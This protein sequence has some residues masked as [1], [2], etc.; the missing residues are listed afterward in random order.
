MNLI[1]HRIVGL[2]ENDHLQPLKDSIADF[3]R[4]DAAVVFSSGF[5]ALKS[6]IPIIP[7][8]YGDDEKAFLLTRICQNRNIVVLPVVSSTVPI[9]LARFC[10]NV[11]AA[12][13]KED[14][15]MV[16][17]VFEHAGKKGGVI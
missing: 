10:V 2:K 6:Q 4:T 17:D 7:L 13:S 5:K 1:K 8:I 3:K 12:H 15:D 16:L 11:A 14:I 9:E